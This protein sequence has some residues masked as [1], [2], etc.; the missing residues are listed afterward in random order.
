MP[1]GDERL[2]FSPNGHQRLDNAPPIRKG[3]FYHQPSHWMP[4][5]SPGSSSSFELGPFM[6]LWDVT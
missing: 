3:D 6:V 4:L 5:G 1:H 2:D